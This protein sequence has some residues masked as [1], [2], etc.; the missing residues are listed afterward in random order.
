MVQRS[1]QKH[2]TQTDWVANKTATSLTRGY[3]GYIPSP[4]V[5]LFRNQNQVRF[6][7]RVHEL[8]EHDL[9]SHGYIIEN[10]DIPIHHY[11]KITG[12]Q[13]L[14]RKCELYLRIGENKIEETPHSSRAFYELGIQYLEMELNEEAVKALKQAYQLSPNDAKCAFN[15]AAALS[16]TGKLEEAITTY[17][18]VLCIDPSHFGAINNIA[19]ILQDNKGSPNEIEILYQKALQINPN[20]H[21]MHY[22]YGLFLESRSDVGNALKHYETALKIDSDFEPART[23]LE[24]LNNMESSMI[25]NNSLNQ[26]TEP[27]VMELIDKGASCLEQ[28]QYA[29]AIE[30]F[31]FAIGKAPGDVN[32]RYQ[33][34]LL[35]EKF[36]QEESAFKQYEQ[37]MAI[38]PKHPGTLLRLAQEAWDQNLVEDCITLCVELLN[39]CP[40]HVEA[41]IRLADALGKQKKYGSA[42]EYINTALEIDPNHSYALETKKRLH[43]LWSETSNSHSIKMGVEKLR[44]A[45]IAGGIPFSGD[46]LQKK[47][48]GGTETA[49]IHMARC[50][51][52]LGHD[53][54]VFSQGGDG[55]WDG[56]QYDELERYIDVLNK[57]PADIVIAVRSFHPFVNAV[58]TRIKL[59]WTEDA[60]DQPHVKLLANHDIVKNVCRIITVSQWQTDNLVNTFGL[61]RDKFYITRNGVFWE[62]YKQ[63][64]EEKNRKKLIYTST[65]F[66]GLDLLL[67]LFPRIRGR[68][69]DAELDIYSSMAVYGIDHQEDQ[70]ENSE[71]YEAAK[72]PG[73]SLLG[74][75]RQSELAKALQKAGIFAYPNTFEETSCISVMEAMAAGLPVVTSHLG[76]LPETVAQGGI[77]ILKDPGSKTYHDAF[78]NAVCSLM[79]DNDRWKQLSD[80]SRNWIFHNNRWEIIAREWIDMFYGLL[81]NPRP[82]ES[83]SQSVECLDRKSAEQMMPLEDIEENRQP[84]EPF[85]GEFF[86][87]LKKSLGAGGSELGLGLTLFSLAV[88]INAANIIEIGRFKGFSTFALA[89]ALKCLDM[90]WQE[91]K[92]HKQRPDIDYALFETEKRRNLFSIDP[93]PTDEAAKLLQ[94]TGLNRYV[95]FMDQRSEQVHIDCQADI[96]FIDGDHSYQ[97]C[98]SDIMRFVPSCLRPGGYFV[99]HDVFGWYDSQGRNGSP[100]KKV[101]DELVDSGKFQHLL[102]D[103]GYQSF[104]VFRK[105][106][107]KLGI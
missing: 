43:S 20:H 33:Y 38:N 36:G 61:P 72:Q 16:K 46:T 104:V 81:D 67:H 23:R 90:G 73:V 103:T 92:Q 100:I 79:A 95:Q 105:I 106:D 69:P 74:S 31:E 68:V 66:R 91:P 96:I 59:F 21:A 63:P 101:I 45:F 41:N 49:I 64:A 48:I 78:V 6:K 27:N 4:L 2:S 55:E 57:Q 99:L 30:A 7:G 28:H 40:Q 56:V 52:K 35:L 76:A 37:I 71:I 39:I 80:A 82:D 65:P 51:S 44:I 22:N 42:L 12:A 107:P 5:R 17:K 70:K 13:R 102:C 19:S 85:F 54:R 25:L 18:Q 32:L 62:D 97:G 84:A 14:N 87:H 58:P 8:V 88:S 93:Y 83:L 47:P 94:E 9:L 10:T 75:V 11:G 3:P 77:F 89:S 50:L 60:H 53:V 98:K 29:E 15:Y 1:Y 24:A 34:G 26:N 86:M